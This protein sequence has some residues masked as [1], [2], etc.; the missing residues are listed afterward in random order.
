MRS[1]RTERLRR[2]VRIHPL[3]RLDARFVLTISAVALL[4]LLISGIAISQILPGYFIEQANQ[5]QFV[6]ADALHG[7]AGS[8]QSK[9]CFAAE[10][11]LAR[12]EHIPPERTIVAIVGAGPSTP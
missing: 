12:R 11:P 1:P 7:R 4:G 6:V 2:S 5:R 3:R 9:N 10:A 8:H